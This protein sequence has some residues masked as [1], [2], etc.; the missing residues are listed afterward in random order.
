MLRSSARPVAVAEQRLADRRAVLLELEHGV[1][2]VAADDLGLAVHEGSGVDR[3]NRA[4]RAREAVGRQIEQAQKDG[5]FDNLPGKGRPLQLNEN[6]FAAGQ[7]TAHNLLRNN[8]YTLGWIEERRQIEEELAAGRAK[9]Q[10]AW[11]RHDGSDW[12]QQHW[13]RA[14][15]HFTTEIAKL[16]QRIRTYNLKAP[17]ANV[18]LLHLDADA[19]V[20]AL[21]R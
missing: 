5:A 7:E 4:Q 9:L 10:Q 3:A 6:P 16:N 12:A 18:H 21:R 15:A 1:E 20:D 14:V 8:G 2:R 13:R 19:E 17:S 11:V